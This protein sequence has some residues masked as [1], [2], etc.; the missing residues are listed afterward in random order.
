MIL[1]IVFYPAQ[2][3]MLQATPHFCV[4]RAAANMKIK[5]GTKNM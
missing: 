5:K 3:A 4:I 2:E 1:H